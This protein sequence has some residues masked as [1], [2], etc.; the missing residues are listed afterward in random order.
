MLIPFARHSD[1]AQSP[2]VSPERLVNLLAEPA[3]PQ[4]KHPIPIYGVSGLT[5]FQTL[6][7]Q[8]IRGA[9][10]FKGEAY[11]TG[12]DTIYKVAEDMSVSSIGTITAAENPVIM[13][14]G[15][16]H[17]MTVDPLTEQGWYSAGVTV[18]EITDVDFPGAVDVTYLDG[19]FI[20]IKPD[21]D[22]FHISGL[23][24]VVNWAALE[25]AEIESFPDKTKAVTHNGNDLI[26]FGENTIEFWFDSGNT[27]FPF[28]PRPG[29][30]IE[31]GIL[32]R[33]T[34]AG[35]ENTVIFVD[36][37][38]SVYRV[39][40]YS[41]ERISSYAVDEDL[42]KVTDLDSFRAFSYVEGGHHFYG[43]SSDMWTWIYDFSTG[44]WHQRESYGLDYW[45]AQYHVEAYT[46]NLAGGD[47]G[48]IVYEIDPDA[49]D[50][51]GEPLLC[52][53]TSPLL[54][55]HPYQIEVNSVTLDFEPG[56]GLATGQGSDPQVML[57]WSRDG[58]KTWSGEH[59]RSLGAIGANRWRAK[60]NRLGTAYVW[61]FRFRISDPVKVVLINADAEA[62]RVAA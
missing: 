20:A 23:H 28:E 27:D 8:P 37:H 54:S 59:W 2:R 46:K 12:Y 40:P 32:A 25:F 36:N 38:R 5:S 47:S 1:P 29:A 13:V 6:P 48:A 44:L 55:D 51:A 26:F 31:Q 4:A 22:R 42:Q 45:R 60:W 35:L 56:V 57:Q 41:T 49:H 34:I 33:N 3:G 21:S 19:Y 58:G 61:C 50:E 9:V 11:F 18:N 7:Q 10:L 39:V 53:A 15:R 62:Q 24:D 16:D 52:E 14:P 30:T 43:L 17:F